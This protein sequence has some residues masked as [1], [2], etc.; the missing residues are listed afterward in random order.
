MIEGMIR[1]VDA[2]LAAERFEFREAGP[3]N[4]PGRCSAGR[5]SAEQG[6]AMT[7]AASREQADSALSKPSLAVSA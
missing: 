2:R 6:H 7:R 4:Q 1:M 3:E 5:C